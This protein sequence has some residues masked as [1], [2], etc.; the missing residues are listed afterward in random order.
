MH[1]WFLHMLLSFRSRYSPHK[2]VQLS[3]YNTCIPSNIA[4]LLSVIILNSRITLCAIFPE[5]STVHK[6]VGKTNITQFEAQ[7][8]QHQESWLHLTISCFGL[9]DIFSKN[10]SENYYALRSQSCQVTM[11]KILSAKMWHPFLVHQYIL[12]GLPSKM[13]EC[14][15]TGL[16]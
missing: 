6:F 10:F 14:C 3:P 11:S 15:Y 8:Q 16:L 4:L 9:L 1:I 5:L 13:R 12:Q 2:A 7:L